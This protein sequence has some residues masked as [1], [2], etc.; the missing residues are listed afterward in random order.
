MPQVSQ[1]TRLKNMIENL[2]IQKDC[3]G[4]SYFLAEDIQNAIIHASDEIEP[5]G[6]HVPSKNEHHAW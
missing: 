6:G 2:P 3:N 5:N 1:A 4:R